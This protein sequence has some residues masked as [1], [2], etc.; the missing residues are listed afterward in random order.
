V[1]FSVPPGAVSGTIEIL[2]SNG[3]VTSADTFIVG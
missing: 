2:A 1:T 3:S